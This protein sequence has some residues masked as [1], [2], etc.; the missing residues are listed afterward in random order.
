MVTVEFSIPLAELSSASTFIV[1]EEGVFP[2]RLHVK[3][4][5]VTFTVSFESLAEPEAIY[6]VLPETPILL[7]EKAAG[8]PF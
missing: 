8:F 3:E 1:T 5:L 7:Q 6:P 2:P 4:Q